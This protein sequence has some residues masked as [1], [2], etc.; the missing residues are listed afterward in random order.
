MPGSASQSVRRKHIHPS[1]CSCCSSSRQGLWVRI[2]EELRRRS[3]ASLCVLLDVFSH[4]PEWRAAADRDPELSSPPP[5]PPPPAEN[6][7]LASHLQQPLSH[8]HTLE[9]QNPQVFIILTVS[10][11]KGARDQTHLRPEPLTDASTCGSEALFTP[12]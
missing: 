12:Q 10:P 11:V 9:T 4:P 2:R 7:R 8:Q 5:P 1:H 6:N 3:R